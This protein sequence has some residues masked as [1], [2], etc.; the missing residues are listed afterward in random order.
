MRFWY[1][2]GTVLNDGVRSVDRRPP[3][4][5]RPRTCPRDVL[6]KQRA[7][8]GLKEMRRTSRAEKYVRFSET[9]P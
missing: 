5:G 9:R 3:V 4:L 2:N 7:I 6:L 8:L 1:H